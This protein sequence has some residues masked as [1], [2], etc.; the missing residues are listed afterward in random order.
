MIGKY[1][2]DIQELKDKKKIQ[3]AMMNEEFKRAR[4]G[5]D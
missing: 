5:A 1:E 3:E 2:Y 4:E